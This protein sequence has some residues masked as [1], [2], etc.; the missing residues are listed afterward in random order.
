MGVEEKRAVVR[1]GGRCRQE[2]W[3]RR[4][5]RKE[6]SVRV[7]RK[8]EGVGECGWSEQAEEKKREKEK[9]QKK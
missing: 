2:G 3:R 1:V 5:R 4:R 9:K 6:S 8:D 7:R